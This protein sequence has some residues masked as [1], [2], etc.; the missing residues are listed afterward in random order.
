MFPS[1]KHQIIF[2]L[3]F[4]A[5]ALT[6]IHGPDSAGWFGLLTAGLVYLCVFFHE[7]G[8]TVFYWLYGYVAV[9]TFDFAHGG[10]MTYQLTD[11]VWMLQAAV[12]A[13]IAYAIW[14]SWRSGIALLC[15]PLATVFLF[16]LLTSLSDIHQAVISFMGHGTEAALAAFFL[17][18]GYFNLWLTRPAERWLNVFLGAFML[19]Y[20][21]MFVFDLMYDAGFAAEYSAQK[22]G[23]RFGDFHRI[24]DETGIAARSLGWLFIA[25]ALACVGV[26][27]GWIARRLREERA[28]AA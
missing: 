2:W 3:C 15:P 27:G 16:L 4:A 24:E 18:R 19:A 10:G 21:V 28:G 14:Q 8:H 26:L 23:H 25:Y 5:G 17:A 11:R 1:P 20:S 6:G 12:F 13:G 22:G 7:I 9:P